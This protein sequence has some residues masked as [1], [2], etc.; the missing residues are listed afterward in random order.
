MALM[1][2]KYGNDPDKIKAGLYALK[3]YPGVSG[4][5]SFDENGD[6]VKPVIFKTVKNKQYIIIK[7]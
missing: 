7:E 6:V 3:N 1:I 4:V 5:T 2:Q